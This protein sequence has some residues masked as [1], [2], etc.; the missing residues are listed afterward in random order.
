MGMGRG[1][2]TSLRSRRRRPRPH[3]DHHNVGATQD[4][5]VRARRVAYRRMRI[6]V[7]AS[8]GAPLGGIAQMIACL[9]RTRTGAASQD[10]RT[11]MARQSQARGADPAAPQSAPRPQCQPHDTLRT[12]QSTH[13]Q[14]HDREVAQPIRVAAISP[15]WTARAGFARSDRRSR[16]APHRAPV[17]REARY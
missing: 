16:Q 1:S 9:S 12:V 6:A 10:H 7:L 5:L 15:P 11:Q 17:R 3:G 8:L 2:S 4:P 13:D 14:S